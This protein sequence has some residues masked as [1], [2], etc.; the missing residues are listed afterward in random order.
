V[1]RPDDSQDPD[2]LLFP[3]GRY[4]QC[5][6]SCGINIPA[7]EPRKQLDRDMCPDETNGKAVIKHPNCES[8]IIYSRVGRRLTQELVIR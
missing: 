6:S 3:S 4:D 7:G 5:C 2:W 1:A 8:R